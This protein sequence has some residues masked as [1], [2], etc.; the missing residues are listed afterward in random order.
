M[1]FDVET[2]LPKK[3]YFDLTSF[4]YPP[5]LTIYH[6]IGCGKTCSA[7]MMREMFLKMHDKSKFTGIIEPKLSTH[8]WEIKLLP[9]KF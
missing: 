7:I 1:E 5:P 3:I 6:G 9:L 8:S 4:D 2:I